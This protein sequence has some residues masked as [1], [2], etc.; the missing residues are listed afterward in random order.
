MSLQHLPTEE[1]QDPAE[2]ALARLRARSQRE[3]F[4]RMPRWR[5]LFVI[6]RLSENDPLPPWKSSSPD[7]SPTQPR[8]MIPLQR[9]K[10]WPIWLLWFVLLLSIMI[11]WIWRNTAGGFL[12]F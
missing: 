8:K 5:A 1:Y 10:L 7:D 12:R 3:R 6:S 2:Q 4:S 9:I 11:L